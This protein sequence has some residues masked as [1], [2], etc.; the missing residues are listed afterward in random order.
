MACVNL[1]I[2]YKINIAFCHY[3]KVIKNNKIMTFQNC[4]PIKA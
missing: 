3:T 1:I 4:L 2:I